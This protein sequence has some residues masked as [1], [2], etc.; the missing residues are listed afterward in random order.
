MVPNVLLTIMVY[1]GKVI[2]RTFTLI[3][4]LIMQVFLFI[5]NLGFTYQICYLIYLVYHILCL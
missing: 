3:T 5:R 2:L 1:F 4:R